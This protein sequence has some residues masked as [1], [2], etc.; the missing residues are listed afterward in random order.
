[1]TTTH[2][3]IH[4]SILFPATNSP[5]QKSITI[6]G[7]SDLTYTL[8][9]RRHL[10]DVQNSSLGF[11]SSPPSKNHRT[12]DARQAGRHRS[13]SHIVFLPPRAE[14]ARPHSHL[15]LLLLLR[16]LLL[17]PA[18]TATSYSSLCHSPSAVPDALGGSPPLTLPWTSTGHF[19]GGGDLHFAQDRYYPHAFYFSPRS[20]SATTDPAVTHLS[21]TLTLEGTRL[22]GRHHGDPHSV[23]FDLDGYHST[24]TGE[25]CM[26]GSGSYARDDGFGVVL[27]SAVVLRLT[28]PR[29]ANLSVPFVTGRLGGADFNHI[30][31]VAYA[32]AGYEYGETASCPP[33]PPASGA[34][35][36]LPVTAAGFSCGRLRA[37]LGR[38]SYSLDYKPGGHAAASGF[39]PLRRGHRSMYINQVR[40]SA[41]ADDNAVRAY[42]VFYTDEPAAGPSNYTGRRWGRGR[43][44]MVGDE[45]LVADG[46]W[47]ASRSRLC[48]RACRVAVAS[49][50][51]QSGADDLAV[52]ECGSIGVS[53]W[54]PAVW[55]VRDR[56]VA[57]GMIWNATGGN[58]DGDA[59]AGGVIAVSRTGGNYR[60][61]MSD[62]KYNY[63]L[64]EDA[65]KHYDA[66][67][68]LSKE[69]KG[70]F[71]GNTS[72]RDFA[73]GFYLKKQGGLPRS[74]YAWPVTIGSA[75]VE[76]NALIADAA[77]GAEEANNK[78]RLLNVSYDLQYYVMNSSG[79]GNSPHQ[80][81]RL[82]AEGVYDTKTGSLCMVACQ[83]V[84]TGSS[85]DCEVLV[86][87]QF[88][89]TDAAA[90]RERAVGK[91]SSLRKKT[92]PLFFEP[93]E[94]V[95]DG[96]YVEQEAD[97]ISR[98]DMESI[99][100]VASMLLSCAFTAL[101][102]RHVK[103]HPEALPATSTTMLVVL[104]LGYA[105]PLVLNLED[106]YGDSN[107]RRRQ[108]FF[109]L[110]SGGLLE[111][112]GL[113]LR[114]TT[115]LALVLQLRLLHLAMSSRRS[116]TDDQAGGNKHDDGVERSTLWVCLPLYALGAVAVWIA[117]MTDA[118]PGPALVG[119]LAAYAGL[120]LD[121][122][123]LPQVVRNALSGYS[124]VRPALSPWFYAGVAAIRAA[125]HA[126]DAF[127]KRGHVLASYVYA[128][129]RDD[130]FGAGWDVAVPCG[131]ALLVA[132]L[133]LQQRR[134]GAFGEKN[135]KR[136]GEYEMVSTLSS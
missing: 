116:T 27:L 40:C 128:S 43:E 109:R 67:P 26:V 57:A 71:P 50:G 82:S 46:F 97:S 99:M 52:S 8:K 103:N 125:P 39:F 132:V 96:M 62:I 127:R 133:F 118:K 41:A 10:H 89:P 115:V 79:N 87:V 47:D 5:S 80:L 19:S 124:K 100:L 123:L 86:T 65:K 37:L 101:Q 72:Y 16:L 119:D 114:V 68:E 17:L 13:I 88:A 63:T 102:L 14:M 76:G 22:A 51:S 105:I 91:I 110:A 4:S 131:A 61:N 9:Y 112:N 84:T 55:S 15:S 29:P 134:G 94:F 64:V 18:A 130:L 122:F 92:D 85:S 12:N 90:A 48:L 31:L 83:Q 135:S 7:G 1:M 107:D 53:F 73:F 74:G 120:V 25:L 11:V 21:A 6:V 106:T 54:F 30:T 77:F 93:L 126:Y 42:M 56:S 70:R 34:R 59:A 111:L 28:V 2:G 23:S 121:G 78:Q 44:F 117:H 98:M 95:G 69:K 104:A 24:A 60:G 32:E 35:R 36:V 33:A 66:M 129:P 38:Y 58:S 75:F 108:Y 3:A 81:R 45:A 113:V 49:S 136:P 20:T